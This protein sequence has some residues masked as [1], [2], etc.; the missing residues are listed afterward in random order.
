MPFP[1][2]RVSMPLSEIPRFLGPVTPG[3]VGE[4]ARAFRKFGGF[5][6]VFP[7]DSGR[8]AFKMILA[9]LEPEPGA[10]IVFPAY[11]FHPMPVLAAECGLVPVFADVRPDTLTMDPEDIERK[12]TE[13]TKAIILVH[14]FGTAA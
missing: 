14:L 11:T 6:P 3:A 10:E 4:F 7:T 1:R 12:I 8:S 9:A 2:F 13:R 5:G